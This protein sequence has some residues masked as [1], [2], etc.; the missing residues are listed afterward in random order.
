MQRHILHILYTLLA[1]TALN[2]CANLQPVPDNIVDIA[3]NVE[4]TLQLPEKNISSM[5]QVIGGYHGNTH[6]INI[7]VDATPTALTLVGLV[8]TGTQLFNIRFDGKTLTHWVSPL[9]NA[10]FDAR[11]VLADYEIANLSVAQLQAALP[12]DIRVLEQQQ[13]NKTVRELQRS[14]G[15]TFIHVEYQHARTTYC[16]RERD[17]CL[18]ITALGN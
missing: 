10:P 1:L 16:H 6:T 9:F 7:H 5:Q 15:E 2:G 17:Y 8:P 3:R 12:A 11:Y 13:Q 18:H 14:N 4:M